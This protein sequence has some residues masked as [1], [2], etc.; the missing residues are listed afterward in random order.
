MDKTMNH[1][2]LFFDICFGST[3]LCLIFVLSRSGISA[4]KID[5]CL[6]L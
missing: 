3:V 5:M 1:K 6:L 4:Y 2:I